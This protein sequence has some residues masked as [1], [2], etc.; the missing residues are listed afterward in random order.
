[1]EETRFP[2]VVDPVWLPTRGTPLAKGD[3]VEAYKEAVVPRAA[4]VTPNAQEAAL[5]A[6][7]PVRSL[8]DAREAAERD[9]SAR[10]VRPSCQGRPPRGLGPGTDVLLHDGSVTELPGR[11]RAGSLSRN[12]VRALGRDRDSACLGARHSGRRRRGQSLA[13][14]RA[15][16]CVRVGK[17]RQPVN[18][19]WPWTTNLKSV[20]SFAN[21]LVARLLRGCYMRAGFRM[22]RRRKKKGAPQIELPMDSIEDASLVVEAQRR[23]LN[24]ALSVITSRA[25]PDV[26]D[27]LKPV[28][29]RILYTMYNELRLRSDV[30]H[31]KSAAIVGDVMG[32]FHPHGDTAIYD[33][34]VRMAQSFT[35]REPLVDGRGNFRL[36]GWRFGGGD[37]LH[38]GAPSEALRRAPGR[39]CEEDRRL[40]AQL[41]RAP[42]RADRPACAL[43]EPVGEWLAGHCGW[44][45]NL[46]SASQF[47][48][49][50]SGLR[51]AHR[52]RP[53]DQAADEVREGA[54]LPDG[55]RADQQQER[56][57]D[58]L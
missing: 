20:R 33:A 7:M 31:R 39:A 17:G 8:E 46:D 45:G 6:E 43:S 56:A 24:Y 42:V 57:G 1:M 37:A 23:Y 51:G 13:H 3:V 27:G 40:S 32:K 12:R 16:P 4:L 22:A 35:M 53:H 10:R 5:L 55:R 19:F 15:R 41:R 30:K 50:D 48:R 36:A 34:L 26:R 11:S 52:R 9:R 14:R 38:R 18:H 2:W 54:R 25:L 47:V 28:Q 21:A 29:R 58:G 49:G 44:D